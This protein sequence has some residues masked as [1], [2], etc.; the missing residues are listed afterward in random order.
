MT[1]S[2]CHLRVVFARCQI[3]CRWFQS[4]PGK[5]GEI[6][7]STVSQRCNTNPSVGPTDCPAS[8]T[9]YLGLTRARVRM[10][11]NLLHPIRLL[12][13]CCLR[14]TAS[15]QCLWRS[16]R[17]VPSCSSV[18]ASRNCSWVF[19]TIGPYQATGSSSGF[20]E[21]RRNLMPSS[22]A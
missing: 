7:D 2:L 8:W 14:S 5:C 18:N 19:I 3:P 16:F 6:H 15:F 1:A 9:M 17:K 4:T 10:K 22:P 21:T 12:Y 11:R 13:R 20:P